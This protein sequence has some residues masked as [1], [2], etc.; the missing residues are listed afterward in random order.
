[1]RHVIDI[2][3]RYCH[4]DDLVKNGHAPTGTHRY[5]CNACR[6]SFQLDYRYNAWKPGTK[7]QIDTLSL[8]SSG[9]RDIGHALGISPDTVVAHLKKSVRKM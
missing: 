8:N 7:D 4:S 2:H 9:V 1:M 5:R 3:C 6:R